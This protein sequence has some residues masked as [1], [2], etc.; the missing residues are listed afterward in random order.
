[1]YRWA[2]PFHPQTVPQEKKTIKYELA[3]F[4]KSVPQLC[5][6]YIGTAVYGQRHMYNLCPS[7]PPSFTY[8]RPSILKNLPICVVAIL[9]SNRGGR[10]EA[11]YTPSRGKTLGHRRIYMGR[12]LRIFVILRV[13]A[14]FYF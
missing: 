7:G 13:L 14:K 10:V 11:A 3:R 5:Y 4:Y 8:E 2:A 12:Q 1:M 6:T 9:F